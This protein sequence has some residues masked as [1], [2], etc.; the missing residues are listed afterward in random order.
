MSTYQRFIQAKEA[1]FKCME[2]MTTEQYQSLGA[3]A[4][5]T[6]CR[7][8]GEKVASFLQ[9]DSVHFKALLDESIAAMKAQQQ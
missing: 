5:E 9:N 4:Q 1:I 2:S 7:S 8:E 3:S 6:V